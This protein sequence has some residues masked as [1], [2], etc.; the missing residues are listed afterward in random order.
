MT[1][2]TPAVFLVASL[3]LVAC[4]KKDEPPPASAAAPAAAAPA[5]PALAKLYAQTCAAC[6]GQPGTGAPQAGVAADWTERKA[7]GMDVLVQHTLEGFKG[8]PPMG[9]CADCSEEDFRKLIAYMA[10]M[11]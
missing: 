1:L 3:A 2:R 10:G 4:G 5:D 7:Q 6:H 9:S 11:S 8:M